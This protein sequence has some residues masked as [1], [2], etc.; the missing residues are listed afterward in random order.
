MKSFEQP[1]EKR[2]S[3]SYTG[4][5]FA[6]VLIV[7]LIV[8]ILVKIK[9]NNESAQEEIQMQR[10][11]EELQKTLSLCDQTDNPQ[12]CRKQEVEETAS[13]VGVSAICES[14]QEEAFVNCVVRVAVEQKKSSACEVLLQEEDRISCQ[15]T[16]FWARAL[17]TYEIKACESLSSAQEKCKELVS[18]YIARTQGCGEQ[19]GVDPSVCQ[20]QAAYNTAVMSRNSSACLQ[21]ET[22]EQQESCLDTQNTISPEDQDLDRPDIQQETATGTSD[23]SSDTDKDGLSDFE[24]SFVYQTDPLNPDTD[25]DGYTDGQEVESGYSPLGE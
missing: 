18:Q 19:T 13:R 17:Q 16:V 10:I 2:F 22:L 3:W 7:F 15:D 25:G 9:T 8:F 4:I 20:K 14:L 23:S 6:G 12:G 21:L 1:Q 11:Q 24:E 5:I